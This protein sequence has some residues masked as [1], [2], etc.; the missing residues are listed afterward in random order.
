MTIKNPALRVLAE[1]CLRDG[2]RKFDRTGIRIANHP[3]RFNGKTME[4]LSIVRRDGR[5]RIFQHFPDP[6]TI[7]I[8]SRAE[9][10]YIKRPAKTRLTEA[11]IRSHFLNET[12]R[13]R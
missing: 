4:W 3:I 10:R 5:V 9:A 1:A 7:G 8:F 13:R 11:Q 6:R 12:R 2:L